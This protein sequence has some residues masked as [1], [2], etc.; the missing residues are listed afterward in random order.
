MDARLDHYVDISGYAADIL[1][2]PDA[3]AAT[4]LFKS[5]LRRFGYDTFS[6]GESDVRDHRRSVFYV[7]D[8]PTEFAM[9]YHAS[10][11][12]AVCPIM[13]ALAFFDKPYCWAD[14]RELCLQTKGSWR[15]LEAARAH[16]WEDG[17]VVPLPRGGARKGIISMMGRSANLRPEDRPLVAALAMVYY[18]RVRGMLTGA[19][20]LVSSAKLTRIEIDCLRLIASGLPDASL[21]EKLAISLSNVHEHVQHARMKLGAKTRAEA[22]ALVVSLGLVA[23]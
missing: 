19:S 23:A 7:I 1:T 21:S 16:G 11:M 4:A 18:E 8:W 15:L 12:I 17:L 9:V 14:M 13:R 3:G 10:D 22:V 20:T 5:L 2:A 6:C